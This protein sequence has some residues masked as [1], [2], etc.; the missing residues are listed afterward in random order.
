MAILQGKIYL[1]GG[2][3]GS[4]GL[5]GDITNTVHVYDLTTGKW[6]KAA[7]MKT[8][9]T[10]ARATVIDGKIY[11]V[12]GATGKPI[13]SIEVYDPAANMWETKQS[14]QG[15]RSGHCVESVGRKVIII[16][17]MTG[18]SLNSLTAVIEEI[19]I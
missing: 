12:G 11:V 13:S 2:L 9:R 10:A 8:A 5:D 19:D 16:G 6:D 1:A 15:P 4:G 3:I 14:M 18:T 7:S 17:G